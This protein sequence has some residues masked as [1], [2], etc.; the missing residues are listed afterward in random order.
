MKFSKSFSICVHEFPKSK[1]KKKQN[2]KCAMVYTAYAMQYDRDGREIVANI[3]KDMETFS[4][5]I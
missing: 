1:Q 3:E 4:N 2:E 5:D